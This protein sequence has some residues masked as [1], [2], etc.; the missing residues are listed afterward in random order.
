MKT[1]FQT[2]LAIVVSLFFL[3]TI[4]WIP[5]TVPAGSKFTESVVL[6]N[7]LSPGKTQDEI[8]I[9]TYGESTM[10]GANYA[11]VSSPARWLETYLRDFLP[12]KKIRMVNF[13]RMGHGSF[14]TVE[15]FEQTLA[16]HPDV[17]IFYLG[18]NDYLPGE[19]MDQ[20]DRATHPKVYYL[21]KLLFQ[22]RFV[23]FFY[24]VVLR[25]NIRKR[26]ARWED[27]MVGEKIEV[28]PGALKMGA[29][30]PRNEKFYWEN[31]RFFRENILKILKLGR[32]H[33]IPVLFLKPVSNLK[34]FLP[35]ESAHQKPLSDLGRRL[36]QDFFTLGEAAR[37]AK[38]LGEA[39]AYYHKA[40]AIDS[41]YAELP[42][43]MGQIYLQQGKFAEAKRFFTEA[44]DQDAIVCRATREILTILNELQKTQGL[45]MLDT[46]KVLEPEALGQIL[47]EPIIEDN[48]HFS[49]KGHSLIGKLMAE[50][51]A[52]QGWIAPANDWDFSR[53]RSYE[54]IYQELGINPDLISHSFVQVASYLGDRYEDRLRVA[55]RAVELSPKNQEALRALAWSY[56]IS[57]RKE[58]AFKVYDQ[59]KILNPHLAVEIL[60][61]VPD[62]K[63]AY[64]IQSGMSS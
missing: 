30:T 48:V 36:W 15:T 21:E 54:V 9:F 55:R 41:T 52:S 7:H 37:K 24:R 23:S 62:L 16:Y 31:L 42:Y 14:F 27:R 34:D 10:H 58:N 44:K 25:R 38:H 28:I 61:N 4:F 39:A 35:L 59:I 51:L 29:A 18:H 56:W 64:E 22:S 45:V 17:A 6:K 32:D 33:R 50:G 3:E 20:V 1:F 2:L 49:I 53:E 46:E 57:G 8:R 26:E 43:R 11:P 5:R 12:H 63:K 47:G 19:R 13:A 60:E 40:Y